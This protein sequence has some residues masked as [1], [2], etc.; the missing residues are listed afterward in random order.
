MASHTSPFPEEEDDVMSSAVLD[1]PD[2][3][4]EHCERTIKQALGRTPGVRRVEVDI[5]GKQV[6]VSYDDAAVDVDR[7][8]A[9]LEAEDYPVA[10]VTPDAR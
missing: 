5:A 9:V 4:C 6:R 10:S 3:S 2:I 1:V 7:L 8:K